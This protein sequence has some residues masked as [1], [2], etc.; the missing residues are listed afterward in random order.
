MLFLRDIIDAFLELPI[1][2]ATSFTGRLSAARYYFL[3]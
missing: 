2:S 3:L 1:A